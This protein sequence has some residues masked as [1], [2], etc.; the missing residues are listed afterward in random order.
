MGSLILWQI[1]GKTFKS[2]AGGHNKFVAG[3]FTITSSNVDN[4]SANSEAKTSRLA[5]RMEDNRLK[6][7]KLS[8][9]LQALIVEPSYLV[10][11]TAYLERIFIKAACISRNSKLPLCPFL[12]GYCILIHKKWITIAIKQATPIRQLWKKVGLW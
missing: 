3:T 10:L 6:L 8:E 2:S 5:P 7:K 4:E 12:K 11:R 9:G 1:I